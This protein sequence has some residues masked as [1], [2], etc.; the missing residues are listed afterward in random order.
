LLK[1][2]QNPRRARSPPTADAQILPALWQDLAQFFIEAASDRNR[3]KRAIS[4]DDS[5]ELA[6][7]TLL[8]EVL[9]VRRLWHDQLAKLTQSLPFFVGTE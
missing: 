8:D 7:L 2:R 6:I 3:G 4:S 5:V 1:S 9:S